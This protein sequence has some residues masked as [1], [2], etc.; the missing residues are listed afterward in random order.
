MYKMSIYIL[1]ITNVYIKKTLYQI[2][3]KLYN[4]TTYSDRIDMENILD[5]ERS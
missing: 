1:R 2:N 3:K 4:T 5:I